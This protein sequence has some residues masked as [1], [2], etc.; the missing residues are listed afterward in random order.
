MSR[1]TLVLVLVAAAVVAAVA[2]GVALAAFGDDDEAA[3]T[4][5]STTA[6]ATAAPVEIETASLATIRGL[7][8]AGQVLGAADAPVTLVEYADLQCPFCAEFS[9]ETFPAVVDRWVRDGR[10]KVD[11]RGLRFLGEDSE[12]ALRFALAAAE[13]DKLWHV[14]ELLYENQGEENSG[15]VTDGLL[16]AVAEAAGLDYEQ[17]R[18]AADALPESAL[19]ELEAQAQADQ[20]EG[21]PAFYVGRSGGTTVAVGTG[22]LPIT[23]FEP[24]I[25]AA[26]TP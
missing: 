5:G 12:K 14:V 1:R 15:W 13:E 16:R 11:F 25:D 2:I 21:T 6:A 8:Q 19:A 9:R 20:V 18:A 10:V 23:A 17:T 24:A 26:L 3:G 22:A 4:E 7:P